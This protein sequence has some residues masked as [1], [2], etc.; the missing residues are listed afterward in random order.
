MPVRVY[1]DGSP[2][3]L[4]E[5]DN[6]ID[7]TNTKTAGLQEAINYAESHHIPL[8]VDGAPGFVDVTDTI[9]IGSTRAQHY[10]FRGLLL[11]SSANGPAI[12]FDAPVFI[13]FDWSGHIEYVGSGQEAVLFDPR[14]PAPGV[15]GTAGGGCV[16]KFGTIHLPFVYV[17]GPARP[18]CVVRFKSDHHATVDMRLFIDGL[19]GGLVTPVG[20]QV[21][22]PAPASPA[23]NAFAENYV[24]FGF[25]GACTSVGLQVGSGPINHQTQPVNSTH[26]VGAINADSNMIAYVATFAEHEIYDIRSMSVNS[27]AVQYGAIFNG[28]ATGCIARMPQIQANNSAIFIG[29]K[30]KVY[31]PDTGTSGPAM[32]AGVNGNQLIQ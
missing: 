31:A 9:V 7:I 20:I 15:F 6:P 16:H 32:G 14:N 18:N 1:F 13:R 19:H 5:H 10:E 2:V 11:R 25:I 24:D 26:W 21:M 28:T 17:T 8:V 30:N 3:V 29:A 12:K 23:I 4:D 27:G 22:N